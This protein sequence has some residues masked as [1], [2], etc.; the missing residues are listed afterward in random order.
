MVHGLSL[1]RLY[2]AE[3]QVWKSI[4]RRCNSKLSRDY[5]RYGGRGITICGRWKEFANFLDDMGCRPSRN[6]QIERRDNNA[7]YSPDNCKWATPKEQARNR[8]SN[9]IVHHDGQRK[10]LAEWCESL[11]IDSSTLA[12]RLKRW[13]VEQAVTTPILNDRQRLKGR[14][15][16]FNGESHCIAEWADITGIPYHVL[17]QRNKAGWG[18]EKVLTT[19]YT[20]RSDNTTFRIASSQ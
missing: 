9:R 1:R 15:L 7:G 5:P 11:G 14:R 16:E 4:R 13:S 20:P 6:H 10:C 17:W 12:S 19:P 18:A 2:P 8:S 3:Y